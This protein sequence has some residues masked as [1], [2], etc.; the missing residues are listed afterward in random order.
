MS[1]EICLVCTGYGTVWLVTPDDQAAEETCT[2]CQGYGL[3]PL[4]AQSPSIPYDPALAIERAV[5]AAL[6]FERKTK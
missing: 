3:A 1:L 4:R 5:A 6:A 2:A